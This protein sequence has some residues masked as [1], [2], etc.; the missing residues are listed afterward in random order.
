MHSGMNTDALRHEPIYKIK[1]NRPDSDYPTRVNCYSLL[2][3]DEHRCIASR[4][5]R[6]PTIGAIGG[7]SIYERSSLFEKFKERQIP[8][9]YITINLPNRVMKESWP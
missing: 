2:R 7:L 8:L 9:Y 5:I 6:S 1:I 4:E 3:S